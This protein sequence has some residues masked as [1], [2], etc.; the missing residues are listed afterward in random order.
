[1]VNAQISTPFKQVLS[2]PR[3]L[4]VGRNV[5]ANLK[6]LQQAINSPTPFVGGVDLAKLAKDRLVISS[7]KVGLSDLCA[8][9]LGKCL[10]KNVP[11]RISSA[12]END[13][14]SSSQIQYAALDVYSSL[15]IYDALSIIPV[16]SP[17]SD[18][19]LLGT[20]IL[21]LND[22]RTRI[23]ARGKIASLEGEYA[24]IKVSKT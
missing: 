2:N 24:G 19:I 7:A 17:L 20:H 9:I 4:K 12:W 6:Y 23:I 11:E 10:A 3:I 14:L 22:D 1:L 21:L 8:T 15:W 5:D 13:K 16:P 18:P